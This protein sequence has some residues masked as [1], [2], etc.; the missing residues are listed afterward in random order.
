[1][2]GDLFSHPLEPLDGLR[3]RL[4]TR[5][6][7]SSTVAFIE[8]G[9]GP[10]RAGLRCCCGRH[11][12]WVS[13]ASYQFLTEVVANFGRPTS[14]IEIRVPTALTQ[15]V[16]DHEAPLAVPAPAADFLCAETEGTQK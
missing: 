7:C 11:A 6:R 8:A 12:G 15:F 3:V 4:P 10:H 13:G 1:M 2:T 16:D 5:C 9:R 14:P